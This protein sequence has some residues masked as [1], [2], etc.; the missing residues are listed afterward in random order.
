MILSV[1]G[2]KLSTVTASAP[3]VPL[4][5]QLGGTSPPPSMAAERAHLLRLAHTVES[6]DSPYETS[7]NGNVI[8]G[9][10]QQR[11]DHVHVVPGSG[12]CTRHLRLELNGAPVPNTSAAP[13]GKWPRSTLRAMDR[14]LPRWRPARHPPRPAPPS[15]IFPK[16]AAARLHHRRR[17]ECANPIHRNHGRT[18]GRDADQ[19]HGPCQCARRRSAS[20]SNSRWHRERTRDAYGKSVGESEWSIYGTATPRRCR[21]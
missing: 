2:S 7:V 18:R 12:R 5:T 4:P 1:F 6:T 9:S 13:R 21:S 10:Q 14:S 8:F 15:R 17:S 16:A 3:R 20:R 11:P 19:L